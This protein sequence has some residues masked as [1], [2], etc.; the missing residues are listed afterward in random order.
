MGCEPTRLAVLKLDVVFRLADGDN[1]AREDK[2]IHPIDQHGCEEKS[3]IEIAKWRND[4]AKGCN[5]WFHDAGKDA[6]NLTRG[7]IA[8]ADNVQGEEPADNHIGKKDEKY[9]R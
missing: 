2:S 4:P 8:M 6:V 5:N 1:E 3:H 9:Q 7:W